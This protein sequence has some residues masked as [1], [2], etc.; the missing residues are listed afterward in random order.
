MAGGLPVP[1]CS[2]WQTLLVACLPSSAGSLARSASQGTP[3]QAPCSCLH[4]AAGPPRAHERGHDAQLRD[5]RGRH[6]LP[7]RAPQGR[8]LQAAPHA[9]S[10]LSVQGADAARRLA[11]SPSLL[12]HCRYRVLN[13]FHRR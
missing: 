5:A 12:V 7:E 2:R 4:A 11:R 1:A 9:L 6:K 3:W 10:R 13:R 8:P